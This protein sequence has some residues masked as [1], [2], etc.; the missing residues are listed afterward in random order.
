[1]IVVSSFTYNLMM[2]LNNNNHL[3]FNLNTIVF[4]YFIYEVNYHDSYHRSL[5]APLF[6]K[7]F[8]LPLV[9]VVCETFLDEAILQFVLENLEIFFEFN[10][11]F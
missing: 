6:K 1:M 7:G 8:D 11:V 2:D 3:S 4:I 10:R 5:C 9:E